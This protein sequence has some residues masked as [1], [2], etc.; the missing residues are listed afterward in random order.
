[1]RRWILPV[2]I[3][4][5]GIAVLLSLGIWQVQRLAWKEGILA[6]IDAK[7]GAQAVALPTS[8][9][10]GSDE[11]LAV[12][13]SGEFSG[14]TLRILASRKVQGAGYRLI[15]AF[16]TGNRV[17]LVDRGFAPL[18]GD[19]DASE[20]AI[21]LEGNLAWPDETDGFTPD[22]DKT[23]NIW[24][25][26]DVA[27]MAAELGTEP[28]LIVARN[29]SP[30]D[31]AATPLAVDGSGIPNDHLEYAITWF[32]LAVVWAGMTGFW[33]FRMRAGDKGSDER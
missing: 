32:S 33:V 8:P 31:P 2:V 16:E 28:I 6:E 12:A 3:G 21:Q 4:A 24:F 20:G 18:D 27:K 22:P 23:E 26:R 1:M 13:A 7:I 14:P 30:A 11:Y 15:T 25:A 9:S 19:I 17:V 29:L 5:G 10:E